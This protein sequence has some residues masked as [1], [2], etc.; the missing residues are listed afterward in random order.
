ELC[1]WSQHPDREGPDAGVGHLI[2]AVATGIQAR[3]ARRTVVG[4]VDEL[5]GFAIATRLQDHHES[6]V[7]VDSDRV[8]S[9]GGQ[10]AGLGGRLRPAVV[11][12][13]GALDVR[14]VEC[15]S[16]HLATLL[17]GNPLCHPLVGL[18]GGWTVVFGRE[19]WYSRQ[20]QRISSGLTALATTCCGI[21]GST[22]PPP[23]K[24]GTV[25]WVEAAR[26]TR[27][28]GRGCCG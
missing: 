24:D 25:R 15:G 27:L 13:D 17:L 1:I 7:D 16:Q 20:S 26:G 28:R 18:R 3:Q 4:M 6:G 2:D 19:L 14:L 5:V 11:G 9:L 23:W 22:L 21:A 8:G 10:E 12:P